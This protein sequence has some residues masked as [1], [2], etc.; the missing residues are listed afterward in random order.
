MMNLVRLSQSSD[1]NTDPR[2]AGM[3]T[4]IQIKH[5]CGH[6][7][8]QK[9]L[10]CSQDILYQLELTTSLTKDNNTHAEV[11]GTYLTPDI[12]RACAEMGIIG[13]FLD[14]DP[15]RR[16]QMVRIWHEIKRAPD[17]EDPKHT[18]DRCN[19]PKQTFDGNSNV[20][21]SCCASSGPA[22][23]STGPELMEINI[24]NF[25][26]DSSAEKLELLSPFTEPFT[27]TA[28]ATDRQF[29][30]IDVETVLVK[31]ATGLQGGYNVH[32][33]SNLGE[34]VS[35]LKQRIMVLIAKNREHKS[36]R[37]QVMCRAAENLPSQA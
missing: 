16:Y 19:G 36:A 13:T 11:S 8:S 12:C 37:A 6:E 25:A 7:H 4:T 24:T 33:V 20:S 21:D 1:L 15:N 22:T 28:K 3:C 5:I 14:Q 27:I 2:I 30:C 9:V 18:D 34:R 35:S 17:P 10:K 26:D 31:P 29:D 32:G 23:P